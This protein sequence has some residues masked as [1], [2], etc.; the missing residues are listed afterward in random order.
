MRRQ[1]LTADEMDQV[2]PHFP[3]FDSVASLSDSTTKPV[4]QNIVLPKTF[5]KP[6]KPS[7]PLPGLPPDEASHQ[8]NEEEVGVGEAVAAAI[9]PAKP[10][11]LP[12]FSNLRLGSLGWED[13]EELDCVT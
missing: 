13:G 11:S 1:V 2:S 5:K 9:T 6:R 10:P 4:L 12:S 7:K 3:S 8:S